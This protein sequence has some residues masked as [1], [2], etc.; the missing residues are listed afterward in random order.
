MPTSTAS[1]G[2]CSPKSSNW[3][4]TPEK[5]ERWRSSFL[6]LPVAQAGQLGGSRDR[7][8]ETEKFHGLLH[9]FPRFGRAGEIPVAEEIGKAL[10]RTGGIGI[11]IGD[12]PP[13]PGIAF[14]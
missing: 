11:E 14:E 5:E 6:S 10:G 12:R 2:P 3:Q 13:A 7:R 4:A 1:N 9:H 8:R